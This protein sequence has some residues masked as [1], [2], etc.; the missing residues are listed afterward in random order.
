MSM[1]N[2]WQGLSN[3]RMSMEI[4]TW[5]EVLACSKYS[6]KSTWSFGRMLSMARMASFRFLS[7]AGKASMIGGKLEACNFTCKSNPVREVWESIYYCFNSPSASSFFTFKAI[8]RHIIFYLSLENLLSMKLILNLPN[9]TKVPFTDLVKIF[10][11][12]CLTLSWMLQTLDFRG[13][14]KIG[15]VPNQIIQVNLKACLRV[16]LPPKRHLKWRSVLWKALVLFWNMSHTFKPIVYC[17]SSPKHRNYPF[18]VGLVKYRAD[19]AHL[20]R[21]RKCIK[22]A[23]MNW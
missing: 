3:D 6:G 9:L 22:N 7:R 16:I 8:L 5:Q 1:I 2:R 13:W 21:L 10:L 23:F 14:N 20:H 15:L 11:A 4:K 18:F 12:G 19:S 17:P